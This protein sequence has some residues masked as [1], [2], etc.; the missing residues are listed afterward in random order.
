MQALTQEW[1]SGPEDP[2]FSV[3]DNPI[4]GGKVTIF[5]LSWGD[6]LELLKKCLGSI[7]DTVP[8]HRRD[9]RIALNQPS[10]NVIGFVSTLDRL[11]VSKVY[12]DRTDRKKYP[13]MH[14]MFNDSEHPVTTRYL[15]WF[16]DDTKA[17]DP[18]WLPKVCQMIVLNHPQKVRL[19]GK[20]MGHDIA[21]YQKN[22]HRPDTWFREAT[23]W[24][25]NPLKLK[26]LARVGPNG[27]VIEFVAGYFWAMATEMIGRAEIPDVRLNHNGGDITIGAQIH[28]A[29]FKI[30]SLNANKELVWCPTKEKGGRRG[31]SEAFPWADPVTKSQHI[32]GA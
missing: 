3:L 2:A 20:K 28:Q 22:G 21:S 14:E 30:M 31:Y 27:S 25:N 32:E 1:V 24:E 11:D 23:W 5:I 18:L 19:Y 15:F 29:G 26:G 12:L 13:A 10:S 9:I 17:V 7:V 16:D 4:L 6:N 8:R